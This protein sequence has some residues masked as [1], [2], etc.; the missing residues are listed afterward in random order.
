MKKEIKI[1]KGLRYFLISLLLAFLFFGGINYFQ[2]N[3]EDFFFFKETKNLPLRA[4]ISQDFF[5]EFRP[6]RNWEIEKTEIEAE[7]AIAVFLDSKGKEKVLFEK[8]SRQKL[9]VASLTKL[10]TALIVL[11]N[12]DLS[13]NVEISEVL[14]EDN[15]QLKIGEKFEI[16]DL[17]YFLLIS[18]DNGAAKALA[19]EMG[20]KSF[21]FLMNKK[22]QALGM[23]RT[24]FVNPTG[25]DP[26]YDQEVSNFSTAQDLVILAKS[27]LRQPLIY[28]ILATSEIEIYSRENLISH[29]LE[30]TN[31]LLGTFPEVLV[32]KTGWTPKARGCLMVMTK[33]GKNK[34]KIISVILGSD[35][36]FEEMEKLI[37]WIDKAYIF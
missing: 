13:Q 6:F 4:Q 35:N 7:A 10:M 25:L 19:K 15:G 3:L 2:G 36:R 5:E 30:N 29:K 26:D 32:G 21:V 33:A 34:G 17:L 11:E 28:K 20:L 16:G 31:E 1:S 22:A 8:N 9:P 27:A 24:F 12:Y 18:S 23:E 14:S 37:S